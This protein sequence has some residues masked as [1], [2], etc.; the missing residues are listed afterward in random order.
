M[1][2]KLDII[3]KLDRNISIAWGVA[4]GLKA[5]FVACRD[6]EIGGVLTVQHHL[7]DEL[8]DLKSE[9]ETKWGAA[10]DEGKG[11]AE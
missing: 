4:A 2:D 9:I 5:F 3:D 6:P 10:S 1:S 7:L 8:E 11:R